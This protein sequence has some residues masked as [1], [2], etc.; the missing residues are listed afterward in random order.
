MAQK[1]A[2]GS[3]RN[4]R[5]SHSK[6]LGVKRYGG[7]HVIPGNILVPPARHAV[8]PGHRRRHGHRP[9]HLRRRRGRGRIRHQAQRPRLRVGA[10]RREPERRIAAA[11][12]PRVD[13]GDVAASPFFHGH[14]PGPRAGTI[15]V[16]A[17]CDM[18]SQRLTLSSVATPA[19]RGRIADLAGD[20]DVAR[21]TARIPYPYSL[22]DARPV[23][24]LHR[25]RRVRARRR[26]RRRR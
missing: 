7:E 3:T 17:R 24:R 5:D 18:R 14:R 8:A 13:E 12:S 25:R 16:G 2:G 21:M 19:T 22:I 9:H 4:G 23:D 20:W 6:R 11:A 26:A 10:R 15:Q 1:K